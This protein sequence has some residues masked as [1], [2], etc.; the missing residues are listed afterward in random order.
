MDVIAESTFDVANSN[1]QM[2]LK[3]FRP[4]ISK[5]NNGWSCLFQIDRPLDLSRVTY[6]ETSLQAL[7]LAIKTASACLYGSELYK[8]G[9][10]GTFGRFGGNLYIPAPKEFLDLAPYPF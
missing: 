6:G 10:L 9:Q 3:V 4:E 7:V 8:N 5:R 1:E 2:H